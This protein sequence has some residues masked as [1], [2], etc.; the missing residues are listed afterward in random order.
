MHIKMALKQYSII[1]EHLDQKITHQK[2]FQVFIHSFHQMRNLPNIVHYVQ[3]RHFSVHVF[4]TH[5]M[6]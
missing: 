1:Y 5:S 3:H 6:Y 4:V 2:M